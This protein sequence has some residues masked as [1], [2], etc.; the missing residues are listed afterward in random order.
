MSGTVKLQRQRDLILAPAMFTGAFDALPLG[1]AIAEKGEIVYVNPSFAQRFELLQ[2]PETPGMTASLRNREPKNIR[3]AQAAFADFQMDGRS[4]QIISIPAAHQSESLESQKLEAVGRLVSGV[5]H[6]FN[7]VLTGIM[8]YCD[9][10][11]AESKKHSSSWHHAE[12]IRMAGQ[13]G[14]ALIGQLMAVARREAVEPKLFSWNYAIQDMKNLLGRLIGENIK[15]VTELEENLGF[16]KMDHAQ[17]QQIILNLVLNARDAMPEGGQIRVIT[18]NGTKAAI[19]LAGKDPGIVP[20]I[21]L[22]VTD[23]GTGMDQET[24]KHIFK[25]FF[26]TKK[27]GTSSGLG[28][29]T[30]YDLVQEMNGTIDID[31]APGKGTSVLIRMPCANSLEDPKEGKSL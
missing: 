9:L 6:D 2:N 1:L 15:L 10:L 17:A 18:R 26:T 8:L 23:N 31:S 11:L 3:R 4:F 27:T 21:E 5:A 25:R 16:V 22:Q 14:A 13:H 28:L 30:V 24:R 19:H 29:A 20:Y 7:N 12:A